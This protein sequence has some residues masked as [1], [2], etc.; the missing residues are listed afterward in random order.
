MQ[1]ENKSL[2]IF[3]M[4]A[5]AVMGLT[6][7]VPGLELLASV[8]HNYI[9]MAPS[10]AVFFI[11][12][13]AIFLILNSGFKLKPVLFLLLSMFVV[14]FSI[15]EIIGY[16]IRADLTFEE[17]YIPLEGELDGVP[18]ARMSPATGG[19]FFLS[20]IAII[21]IIL[22]RVYF[23][24]NSVLRWSL[25]GLGL[26]VLLV[27][28]VFCLAYLYGTPLL[29]R[30]G[31]LI[32]VAL[33]TAIGFMFLAT[34]ILIY[35]TK[36]LPMEELAGTIKRNYL[37][38]YM[39]PLTVLSVILGGVVILYS[40]EVSEILPVYISAILTI[41]MMIVTAYIAT[42]ISRDISYEFEKSKQEVV[43]TKNALLGS[44]A[45]WRTLVDILPDFLWLKDPDGIYLFCN[46][47][48]EQLFGVK[49][50]EIIGKTDYSLVGKALADVFRKQDKIA[51]DTN[52]P[53]I[54]EEELKNTDGHTVIVETI[55]TPM[56]REDGQ[57][58]G[59]LGIARDITERKD[60]EIR[61]RNIFTQTF[62]FSGIVSLDGILIS[63][64]RTSLDF[65]GANE[66]EVSN[67]FFWDTPWW[68]HSQELKDW[69]KTG[70]AQ[71]AQGKVIQHEVTHVSKHGEL[72]YFE[73]SLK[74]VTDEKGKPLYLIPES[75]DITQRKQT[76]EALKNKEKEQREILNF[77]IDSVISIDE[78]GIILSF[79]KA[80]ETLFGYTAEEIIG[81]SIKI[82]MPE[83]Y[84]R[85]HDQYMQHYLETGESKVIGVGREVEG[86]RKNKDVFS[87]HLSI[88]ELPVKENSKRRF[89]GSCSD[90]TEHK[91]QEE[92][93]RRTQK[94]DALGKLTSGIAHDYNNMLGVI[95]GYS[96][97]LENALKDQPKFANYAQ[98]IHHAGERGAKLTHKLLAFSRHIASDAELLNINNLLYEEQL[99]LEKTLTARIKLILDLQG[100]LWSVWMDGGDLED[101]VLNLSINA[102]HAMD[103]GGQ[104]TFQTR[105]RQVSVTEA[106]SLQLDE[107]DYVVLSIEDTGRGMDKE[108][109]SKIFDPFFSTK[110]NKGTGLGLSQVYGFVE[111]SDGVIKVDSEPGK[112]TRFD[113]YFPR[114]RQSKSN[115]T[116]D[117][118]LSSQ[119]C[120]GSETVLIVDDE[121][122]LLSLG[123]E[124]LSE[125]GYKTLCAK[126]AEQALEILKTESIDVLFSD[127]IMQNMDGYELA[128]IVQKK[129][130]LI[131]TLLT[132][133][134]ANVDDSYM[135]ANKLQHN[136]LRKPYS[137]EEF[138]K[139]IRRL[140]D[141]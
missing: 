103:T 4:L 55:K 24:T 36:L 78:D 65:I 114:Y 81:K 51:I 122:S 92:I 136:I 61:Y 120:N 54:N 33:T 7:Y 45:R 127:V 15:L 29:Y 1:M 124:I 69:L 38:R 3:A 10:T 6:G 76:E 70:I 99:I 117:K 94:M 60:K 5:M 84:A 73:F 118:S 40:V 18:I 28:F 134:F 123:K 75:R 64:N 8:R 13:A 34:Y 121:E 21:I 141:A 137:S 129:Y 14:L 106:S 68:Q 138:I 115:F 31:D 131:K 113:L 32:P 23:I 86:L 77:M 66:A 80:A 93:I 74:P 25:T 140:L 110:G 11:L 72:H 130:P 19:L 67:K 88:A 132:S 16:F 135:D 58:L 87:M 57:L 112:G 56:F 98:L 107:G 44:E 100:D 101:A 96:D 47:K 50:S 85:H 46:R 111:R 95:L 83:E 102:M 62:Q 30:Q 109:C 59:V 42:L 79:N 43:S 35:E 63:A 37:F 105:N 128:A 39:L 41:L 48:V 125:H 27:S 91:Q 22:Q 49:K 116:T 20:G 89:I 9:P 82:L 133:G 52:Q 12:L 97:I 2:F 108:T 119:N 53:T 139:R 71:A 17:F 26:V 104:L 126:S 90:L